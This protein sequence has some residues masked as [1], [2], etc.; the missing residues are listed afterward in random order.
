MT[1][2]ENVDSAYSEILTTAENACLKLEEK[3]PQ[4]TSPERILSLIEAVNLQILAGKGALSHIENT[5]CLLSD[6]KVG[7]ALSKERFLNMQEMATLCGTKLGSTTQ[8]NENRSIE[9]KKRECVSTE[10]NLEFERELAGLAIRNITN[11]FRQLSGFSSAL[12]SELKEIFDQDVQ[13]NL[14]K[15]K[16]IVSAKWKEASL[17]AEKA[18]IDATRAKDLYVAVN[19][20]PQSADILALDSLLTTAKRSNEE[21]LKKIE[22]AKSAEEELRRLQSEFET[23]RSSGSSKSFI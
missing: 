20:D 19:L 21:S 18:K 7:L 16:A 11:F 10:E 13:E 23:S 14:K 8:E 5:K 2:L 4:K 6:Q 22:E 3:Y 1:S 9:E 17:A 12:K 15:Q